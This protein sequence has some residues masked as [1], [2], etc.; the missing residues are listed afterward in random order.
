MNFRK[1]MNLIYLLLMDP[2]KNEEKDTYKDTYDLNT[3]IYN[4]KNTNKTKSY[5]GRT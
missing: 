2:K 3:N 5:L 1:S 4:I